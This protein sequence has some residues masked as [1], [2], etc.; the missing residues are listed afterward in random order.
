MGSELP[1]KGRSVS[2]L[3]LSPGRQYFWP[4]MVHTPGGD[5]TGEVGRQHPF[6]HVTKLDLFYK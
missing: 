6:L 5:N 2:I 4:S 1:P 3:K